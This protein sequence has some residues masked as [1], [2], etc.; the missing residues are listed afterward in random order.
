MNSDH[1]AEQ[2]ILV[3]LLAALENPARAADLATGD[4]RVVAVARHHRLSPLLSV[5]CAETLPPALAKTFRRDRV[6]ATARGMI[7]AQVAEECVAALEAHGVPTIVL[8]G[9]DYE[10]RLYGSPGLRPTGDVDLLVPNGCRRIAFAALDQLGFEPRAAAPGFDDADYHEVAWRRGEV[11][12]D[13]H[14][15]LAP[16]ARCAIDYA[17][18]WAQREPFRLGRTATGVLGRA[19]A[20]VFQALHMTIDHFAVPAIYL[21][22]LA[23]LMPTAA[24]SGPVQDTAAAWKCRRPLATAIALTAAYLPG[25]GRGVAAPVST[26]ASRIIDR[27]G[28]STPLPRSEQLV[29]KL[30]HFDD[31]PQAALY[32]AVQAARNLRERFEVAFRRRPPRERLGLGRPVSS[33][34]ATRG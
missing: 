26:M 9:L 21:V 1:C 10:H 7:L 4:P 29:R 15:G 8:K 20:A 6:I 34:R 32:L 3:T 22:D 14:M 27:F 13:L 33:T 28:T 31:T 11:E 24:A 23:R 5:D 30:A 2:A 18:V 12:V 17:A 25:W 19:H 16:S